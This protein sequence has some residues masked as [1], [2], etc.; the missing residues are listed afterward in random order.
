M[1]GSE[2]K[3]Q[4]H[5]GSWRVLVLL[6]ALASCSRSAEPFVGGVHVKK[7][8]EACALVADRDV[9][10]TTGWD[11]RSYNIEY[12]GTDEHGTIF[13]VNSAKDVYDGR[14]G[15]GEYSFGM[16]VD[17]ATETVVGRY[18]FE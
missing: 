1:G 16:A 10:R 2:A 17:C 12:A 5:M 7:E 11:E 13:Y 3:K 9:R 4:T 15:G 6:P 14:V 8:L 18:R